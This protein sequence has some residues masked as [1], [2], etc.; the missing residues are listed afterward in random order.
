M[1]LCYLFYFNVSSVFVNISIDVKSVQI[2]VAFLN[3]L[4]L[5]R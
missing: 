5:I 4:V 2:Y 1:I 3:R